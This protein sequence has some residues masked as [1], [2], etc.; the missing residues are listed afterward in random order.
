MALPQF[1]SPLISYWQASARI[2]GP[3]AMMDPVYF[4]FF[5]WLKVLTSFGVTSENYGVYHGGGI[6]CRRN[7]QIG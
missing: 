3:V 5:A 2:F 6:A 7:W 1:G 4:S